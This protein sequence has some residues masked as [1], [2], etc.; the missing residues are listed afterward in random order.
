MKENVF[1]GIFA[2]II[3]GLSAYLRVLGIPLILLLVFMI[4]DYISGM[5]KAWHSAEL[6]SHIG[7]L[8]IIKKVSYFAVVV[9]AGGVDWLICAG[10]NSV[11]IEFQTNFYFGLVVVVWFII[12][13]GLSILENLST[14]GVPL[15]AFLIKI[16]KKLKTTV[17]SSAD[18]KI[19]KEG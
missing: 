8:G 11:G 5:L 15:P 14:L 18:E 9:V 16:I 2:T 17:E 3:G 7:L 6:S 1:K 10:I 4:L 19:G 12:N 13:E